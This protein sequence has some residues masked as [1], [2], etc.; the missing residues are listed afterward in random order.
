M[1]S[2]LARV[3]FLAFLLGL[4]L[5][6][7]AQIVVPRFAAR[8]EVDE[9]LLSDFMRLLRSEI[10]R[11]TGL[12]LSDGDLVTSGLAG[13]LEPEFAYFIASELYGMR[14]ALLGELA[15]EASAAAQA[16]YTVSLLVADSEEQ[17]STDVLIEAFSPDELPAVASRL[18]AEVAGFVSQV[19]RLESG[20]AGLFI[21]STPGEAEVFVNGVG[22]GETSS[23]EVLMLKPGVYLLE[24]RKEGFLPATRSVTLHANETELVNVALTAI[25]GGSIRVDSRPSAQVLLDGTPVGKTP[26]TVQASPGARRLSLQRPGFETSVISVSVQNYRVSRVDESLQPIFSHMLFWD[27]EDVSLLYIDGV[28]RTGG[29]VS[30]PEPGERLIAYRQGGS[31]QSFSVTVPESGVF[32]LD[33]ASKSLRP[34]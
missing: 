17:R 33:F 29:F 4:G 2:W 13:S 30:N 22:V 32:E 27:A 5:S 31:L 28:L 23:L 25:S 9:A 24:L 3:A 15:R 26:L 21:S 12:L 16:S 19:G 8:G 7:Q 6:A 20:S 18:A 1:R 10:G 11:Q 14:Y 34:L